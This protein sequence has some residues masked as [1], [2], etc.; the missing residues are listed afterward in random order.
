MSPGIFQTADGHP[1]AKIPTGNG[2]VGRV[3]PAGGHPGM[4]HPA[5]GH[6]GGAEP[7]VPVDIGWS[8]KKSYIALLSSGPDGYA[9]D[10]QPQ[11]PDQAWLMLGTSQDWMTSCPPA[12]A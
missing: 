5:G 8:M 3:H 9:Y 4:V 7:E 2:H 11:P 12:F 1:G 6:P 10:W